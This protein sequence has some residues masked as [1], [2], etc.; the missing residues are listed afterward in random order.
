VNVNTKPAVLVRSQEFATLD[1]EAHRI[2]GG[3][4]NDWRAHLRPIFTEELQFDSTSERKSRSVMQRDMGTL[5]SFSL[6]GALD[7][8]FYRRPQ[9]K[10]TAHAAA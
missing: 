9:S 5:P 10:R 1:K 6:N 8:I 3:D 4:F 7:R 2:V